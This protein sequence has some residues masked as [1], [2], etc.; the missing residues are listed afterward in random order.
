MADGT[1][2]NAFVLPVGLRPVKTVYVPVDL[3]DANNGRLEI[4][5]DGEVFVQQ[6]DDFEHA[7]CFTSLDGAWFA[8]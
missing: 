3:C 1:V 6:G 4:E 8:L 2:P 7:T 5:H